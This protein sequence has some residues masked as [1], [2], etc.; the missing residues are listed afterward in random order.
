MSSNDAGP[1]WIER[2]VAENVALVRINR[3]ESLNALNSVVLRELSEVFSQV[4]ANQTVR[5]VVLTGE[6]KAFVAGADIAEL[7]SLS[8][9][10]AR[11]FAA[12]GQQLF[13]KIETMDTPVIAAV[14]GFALGGGCELAMACDVR[15]AS[16]RAKFGQPEVN[17][18][19]IP[20][21]AGTQRLPRLVGPGRAKLLILSGELIDAQTALD[22]GLVDKVVPH[23][24]LLSVA[25]DLARTIASK[26]PLAVRWAK[27]VITRGVD[28]DLDAGSS[29]ENEAFMQ[30]FLTGEAYEG[31]AAFLEKRAPVWKQS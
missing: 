31:L 3:P 7:K 20:G 25:M 8:P 24:E 1:K 22:I 17:L 6:G 5:A 13:R 12:F 14:N 19:L 27:R 16:D 15:I 23:D 28:L 18:G 29:L 26:G 21:F 10:Q 4:A 9:E 30:T 11:A 2:T